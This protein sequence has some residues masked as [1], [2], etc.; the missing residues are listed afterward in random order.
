MQIGNR[1]DL[2]NAR[3]AIRDQFDAVW[4]QAETI[5]PKEAR[6]IRCALALDRPRLH[7]NSPNWTISLSGRHCGQ[8]NLIIYA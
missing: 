3:N 6:A 8:H 5:G 4:I 1:E 2:D 7:H